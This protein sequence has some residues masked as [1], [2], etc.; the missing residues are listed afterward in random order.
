[1][2]QMLTQFTITEANVNFTDSYLD[3]PVNI[4]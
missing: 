1:M 4:R 3:N 2:K